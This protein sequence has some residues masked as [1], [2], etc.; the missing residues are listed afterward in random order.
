MEKEYEKKGHGTC[1]NED[2]KWIKEEQV[3]LTQDW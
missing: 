1:G 3:D 2:K